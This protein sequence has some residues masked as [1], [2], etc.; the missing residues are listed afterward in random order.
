M[1]ES[2]IYRNIQYS[3]LI[4]NEI[5]AILINCKHSVYFAYNVT[6]AK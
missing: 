1:H 2:Y 4:V 6:I 5:E 3:S